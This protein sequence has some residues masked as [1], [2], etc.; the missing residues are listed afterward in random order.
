IGGYSFGGLVA[1]EMARQLEE[2]NKALALLVLLDPTR[3]RHGRAGSANIPGQQLEIRR[4]NKKIGQHLTGLR[5]L[6]IAAYVK[7]TTKGRIASLKL[8]ACRSLL[9]IG[10]RV[11]VGLRQFYREF[12]YHQAAQNYVAKVYPGRAVL[13]RRRQSRENNNLGDWSELLS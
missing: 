6:G 3:P 13:L 2:Q 4:F 7:E 1:L 11:P 8:L 9:A 12:M 10:R 5:S